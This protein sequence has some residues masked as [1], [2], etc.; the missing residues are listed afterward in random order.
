MTMTGFSDPATPEWIYNG[1]G[2]ACLDTLADFVD[3]NNPEG[4]SGA[5]WK[6]KYFWDALI[7]HGGQRVDGWAGCARAR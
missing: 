6:D 1:D 4:L 2:I 3:Q 7:G 5:A